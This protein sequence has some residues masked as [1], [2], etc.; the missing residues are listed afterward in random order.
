ML[1]KK[2]GITQQELAEK[3]KTTQAVVSRLENV[4]V[5]SSLES[6]IRLAESLDAVV[7]V[8]LTPIED[9]STG[10]E[11]QK[12]EAPC[13]EIDDALKGIVYFN[14]SPQKPCPNVIWSNF[15]TLTGEIIK[16]GE[17]RKQKVMEIA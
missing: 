17:K 1:R 11:K 4:S 7:E 3:A 13:K 2:R 6:V 12:D 10:E 8:H 16:P 9:L 5:H 15:N 14:P